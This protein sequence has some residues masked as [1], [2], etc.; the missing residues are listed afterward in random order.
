V[1]DAPPAR[2]LR[3]LGE[4]LDRDGRV[5]FKNG[6]VVEVVP[7]RDQGYD[8][9]DLRIVWPGTEQTGYV[10]S[11]AYDQ[12]ARAYMLAMAGAPPAEPARRPPAR[13]RRRPTAAEL[14]RFGDCPF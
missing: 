10:N 11:C 12:L 5:E 1:A 6:A 9:D 3:A 13:T 14:E 4:R 2:H 7:L 8:G